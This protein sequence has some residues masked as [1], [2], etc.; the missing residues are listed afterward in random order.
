MGRPRIRDPRSV[1]D[2]LAV[3]GAYLL[4]EYFILQITE[5]MI[6]RQGIV[7]IGT[8]VVLWVLWAAFH[9]L[10]KSS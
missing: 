2:I 8:V 1:W 7:V 3:L 9:I 6:I 10:E 4:L 5:N